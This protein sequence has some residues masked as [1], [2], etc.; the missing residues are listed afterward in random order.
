M[1]IHLQY[2]WDNPVWNI[3]LSMLEKC[4]I[5]KYPVSMPGSISVPK[6]NCFVSGPYVPTNFHENRFTTFW[7]ILLHIKNGLSLHVGKMEKLI[8]YPGPNMDQSKK[9]L[10]GS[11]STRQVSWKLVHKFFLKNLVRQT[12]KPT[13]VKT[14]S[15]SSAEVKIKRQRQ[16]ERSKSH[17][18]SNA[19]TTN[20]DWMQYWMCPTKVYSC[21]LLVKCLTFLIFNVRQ[22]YRAHYSYSLSLCLSVRHTLVLCRKGSRA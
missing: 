1:N 10:N 18:N 2:F 14:L 16:T 15:F 22:S 3:Y 20:T 8:L 11:C 13:E 9:N 19:H 12:N 5:W 6:C 17:R 21:C 7:V 4:K